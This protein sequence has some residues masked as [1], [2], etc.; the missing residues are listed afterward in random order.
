MLQLNEMKFKNIT[1]LLDHF[2][3]EATCKAHLEF[4]RWG[5]VPACHH[6][7]SVNV[8]RTNRGFKCGEKV[9]GKKFTVLTGTIYE[10]TK[11]PIRIWF[12]AIYLATSSKKGIS[13]L[14]ASRQL[15]I[16]QK[17]AW[18]L[19]HRIRQMLTEKAPK[20]LSGI[21]SI[22]ETF[23]GGKEG[24]K[25]ASKR[26]KNE[27]DETRNNNGKVPVL[28][29]VEKQGQIVVEVLPFVSKAG[30]SKIIHDT[31]IKGSVTVTDNFSIYNHLRDSS[32]YIHVVVD[33]SKGQYVNN[34]FSTNNA[35]N[36]FS[37]FKRGVIGI[38]HFLSR[39][40]LQRYCNEFS[41]RYNT[42][43][44]RDDERFDKSLSNA[45]GQRLKYNDLIKHTSQ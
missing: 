13:S 2:K 16:T 37:I 9:C 12:A 42:R 41:F 23:V 10:N 38:Y 40:H 17:S 4:K 24:N 30:I 43:K 3:D 25:H 26:L 7:G 1:Q 6:C 18:F 14:Q 34:G 33:H 28:A 27:S 22:D 45:D 8:Y 21:V 11:L 32:F 31:I 39:E 15:G 36:F 20:L 35:E 5:G 19:N 44:I 29:L